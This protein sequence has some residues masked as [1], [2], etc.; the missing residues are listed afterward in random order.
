MSNK[1]FMETNEISKSKLH[2]RLANL[3]QKG[4]TFFNI[5][6][7][8][9]FSFKSNYQEYKL[10]LLNNLLTGIEI[11]KEIR[12]YAYIHSISTLVIK[13]QSHLPTMVHPHH[14]FQPK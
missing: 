12:R 4:S 8:Q 7:Q 3:P 14:V 9:N 13:I 6:G 11:C 5:Q 2:K 10:K 1:T